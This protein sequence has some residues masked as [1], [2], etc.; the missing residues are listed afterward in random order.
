MK[1]NNS[2]YLP[3]MRN[4]GV[5]VSVMNSSCWEHLVIIISIFYGFFDEFT[6][7][8]AFDNHNLHLFTVSEMN[9]SCCELLVIMVSIFYGF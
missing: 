5:C 4:C 3:N 7:L 9:S 2:I 8:G 1:N 6:V